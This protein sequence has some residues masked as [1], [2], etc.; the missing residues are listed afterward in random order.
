MLIFHLVYDN[1]PKLQFSLQFYVQSG[2]VFISAINT[3]FQEILN[4]QVIFML[5]MENQRYGRN[6]STIVDKSI[7]NSGRYRKKFDAVTSNKKLASLFYEKAKEMLVHRSGT[8]IEDMYWFDENGAEVIAA[9]LDET[10]HECIGYSEVIKRKISRA[11]NVVAMH[12]HP[13][14]MPPS[15]DDFNAAF[16]NG[17]SYGI[18]ICHD[19]SVFVYCAEEEIPESLF[20]L[21]YAE[22]LLEGEEEYKAYIKTI[23]KMSRSYRIS[24]Q[25]VEIDG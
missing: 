10:E 7:I 20:T 9:V 4:R 2:Q 14:S 17:Y 19:G 22:Y 15:V 12:T 8:E 6:K 23:E 5:E 25:E 13:H 3:L 24:L 1:I 18:V 11:Q 21:Q 16:Q